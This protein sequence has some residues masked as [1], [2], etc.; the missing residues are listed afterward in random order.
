M[1]HELRQRIP[2]KLWER[3]EAEA[4]RTGFA[5]PM[6][7]IVALDKG[8]PQAAGGRRPGAGAGPAARDLERAPLLVVVPDTELP[9][10]PPLIYWRPTK[11]AK[12]WRVVQLKRTRDGSIMPS[13][14]DWEVPD[15]VWQLVIDSTAVPFSEKNPE[16]RKLV[17]RYVDPASLYPAD[18]DSSAELAAW[19]AEQREKNAAG[20]DAGESA[21]GAVALV[22]DD[23]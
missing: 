23:A 12:E 5:P 8:L 6:V 9:G 21:P 11:L 7:I 10:Q 18:S 17:Q 15:D 14:L 3:V 13:P 20:G 1:S 2:D 4:E 22:D 16:H 19:M